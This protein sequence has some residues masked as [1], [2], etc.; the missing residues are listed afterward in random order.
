[1]KFIDPLILQQEM[2]ELKNYLA[3]RKITRAELVILLEQ[4]KAIE[5]QENMTAALTK[6]LIEN[7]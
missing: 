2:L 7:D 6:I 1:M 3:T 5:I 4:V